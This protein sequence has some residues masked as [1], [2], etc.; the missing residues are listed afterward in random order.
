MEEGLSHFYKDYTRVNLE[1]KDAEGMLT[2]GRKI[3][4]VCVMEVHTKIK[5]HAYK[6][7]LH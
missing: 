7:H 5:N 3:F 6:L 4:K 2:K 1:F